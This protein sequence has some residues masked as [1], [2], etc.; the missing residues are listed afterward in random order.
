[1]IDKKD[2]K[3]LLVTLMKAPYGMDQKTAEAYIMDFDKKFMA[4]ILD[5]LNKLKGKPAPVNDKCINGFCPY[6]K[7]GKCTSPKDEGDCTYRVVG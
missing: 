4:L 6:Q 7:G 2:K 3:N 5:D 1:M